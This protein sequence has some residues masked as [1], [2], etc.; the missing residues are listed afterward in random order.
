MKKREFLVGLLSSVVAFWSMLT[1]RKP[2]DDLLITGQPTGGKFEIVENGNFSGPIPVGKL[3]VEFD[4]NDRGE[5]ACSNV[6]S[7]PPGWKLDA[8]WTH[9]QECMPVVLPSFRTSS[10]QWHLLQLPILPKSDV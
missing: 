3:V 4:C 5:L 8:A 1:G 7:L 2:I 10:P 6:L 9:D